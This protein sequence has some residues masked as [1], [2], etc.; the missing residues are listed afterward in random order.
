ME[1]GI[2][3]KAYKKMGSL[4]NKKFF[5]FH[6]TLEKERENHYI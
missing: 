3:R 6:R 2:K 4:I 1:T 5:I